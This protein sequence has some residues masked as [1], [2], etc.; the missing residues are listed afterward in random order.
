MRR[1]SSSVQSIM[2]SVSTAPR[3]SPN[4]RGRAVVEAHHRNRAAAVRRS[5]TVVHRRTIGRDGDDDVVTTETEQLGDLDRGDCIADRRQSEML[6]LVD[7]RGG[8]A[9]GFGEMPPSGG[10]VEE[11]VELV[12]RS[13]ADTHDHIGVHHVVDQRDV[14]VADALDVVLAVAVLEH[15]RALERLDRDD[16]RAVTVLE[17]VTRAERARGARR[18]HERRKTG[19]RSVTA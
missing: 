10:S 17:V 1:R 8:D 11:H 12:G 2:R 18:R 4:T 15:R 3:C 13:V 14:L 7:D 16:D 5:F 9:D 6:Q 19:A